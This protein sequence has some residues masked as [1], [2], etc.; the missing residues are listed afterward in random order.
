V[1]LALDRVHGRGEE[2]VEVDHGGLLV[3]RQRP[4][5]VVEHR[6]AIVAGEAVEE[7]GAPDAVILPIRAVSGVSVPSR[8]SG[9][10]TK[11]RMS[12]SLKKRFAEW[13]AGG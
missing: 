12:T 8:K 11:W 6:L 4:V 2:V 3:S 13:K 10:T 5:V 7:G 1:G 9:E